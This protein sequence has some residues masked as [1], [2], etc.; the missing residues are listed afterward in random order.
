MVEALKAEADSYGIPLVTAAVAWVLAQPGVSAA[1][2][3]ASKPAQLADNLRGAE[4]ELPD[5]LRLKLDQ[6][7]YDLPRRPPTLDTPRI[8]N[9]L[10]DL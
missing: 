5:G 2:I 4:I 3:G 9:F 6:A 10:T 7:W 8:G 1:I